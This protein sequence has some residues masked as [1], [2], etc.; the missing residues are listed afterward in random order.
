[1]ADNKIKN[2]FVGTSRRRDQKQ[3]EADRR[4]FARLVSSPP[5]FDSS[6]LSP[7]VVKKT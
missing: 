4:D 1:M 2:I 3:R 5:R 7:F 6:G